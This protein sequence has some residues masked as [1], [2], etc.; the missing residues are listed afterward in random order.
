MVEESADAVGRLVT[1]PELADTTSKYFEGHR[2][3]PSS[4]ESYDDVRAEELWS[5]NLALTVRP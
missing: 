2:E 3:I 1:D 4:D 5:G